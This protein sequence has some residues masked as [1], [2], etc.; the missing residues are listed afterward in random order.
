VFVQARIGM[1]DGF[2]AAF[3]VTGIAAL[4]WAMRAPEGKT[5][6]RWLLGSVL[7][8]LGVA[9]K[10]AAAPYI[11]Y[12]AVALI[13]IRLR[14]ARRRNRSIYAALNPGDQRYWPGLAVVPALFALGV[15][16]IA[17]YCM[18]FAPAFFYD[19][20]P[21]TADSFVRFQVQMY[22]AQ[23][24]VLPAHTYQSSWPTWPLMI[25]PIWYLY[26]AVDGATRG[27]LMIGNPAIL[28]SGLIAVAACLVVG[29][30]DR[31]P[32]LLA[33]AGLW[34]A[35]YAMWIVIPKSLGFFYYYYLPSI[36]LALPLAAI[37]DRLVR[38]GH[39]RWDEAFLGIAGG[40][41]V[42]FYPI[43]SAMPLSDPQAFTHWMWF[44]TWP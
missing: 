36:F 33:V 29:L 25:R 41:F 20:L 12:A 40:L 15:A 27:I 31:S 14:D 38:A 18:T 3:V 16:S 39:R 26:E 30:H 8:G 32:R 37:C 6:P 19:Q 2:M 42:Y 35:S 28:W 22:A 5:W 34:I 43:I 9:A 11:A 23:T 7:L 24:Q 10:W 13:V 4:L 44:P 1:L 17:T 21:L